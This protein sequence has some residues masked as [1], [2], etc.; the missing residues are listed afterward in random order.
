MLKYAETTSHALAITAAWRGV[1]SDEARVIVNVQDLPLSLSGAMAGA[2]AEDA[3]PG[4]PVTGMEVSALFGA[5]TVTAAAAWNLSGDGAEV[6]HVT[7]HDGIAR[8][9][10]LD[11]RL[12][13]ETTPAYALS[14]RATWRGEAAAAPVVVAVADVER[15]A[16]L[17][18]RSA[19]PNVALNTTGARV[20][21]LDLALLI[22]GVA[23]TNNV[24]WVFAPATPAVTGEAFTID[25]ANGVITLDSPVTAALPQTY[26]VTVTATQT[27]RSASLPLSIR[28]APGLGVRVR[29]FLEGAVIP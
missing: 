10:L 15:D 1:T 7:T 26:Q 2:I 21:G 19:A 27:D 24:E 4:A 20:A 9:R 23:Q 13:Y 11:A 17:V 22:D 5:T 25:A 28:V 16:Q 8:L 6:F 29:V 14:L 12:D 3:A 18:D